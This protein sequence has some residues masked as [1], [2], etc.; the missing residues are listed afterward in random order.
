MNKTWLGY[1]SLAKL[2]E[3]SIGVQANLERMAELYRR[4]TEVLAWHRPYYQCYYG[5]CLLRDLGIQENE[6]L[7]GR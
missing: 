1:L 2:I 5:L 3:N 7:N 6:N 4:G